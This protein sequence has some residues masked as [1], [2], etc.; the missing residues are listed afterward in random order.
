MGW[1]VRG[2]D[3]YDGETVHVSKGDN[4][5]AWPLFVALAQASREDLARGVEM[6]L[7]R[8][9]EEGDYEIPVGDSAFDW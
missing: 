8:Q 2:D 5:T 3:I 9:M 4:P 7:C 1:E 6:G